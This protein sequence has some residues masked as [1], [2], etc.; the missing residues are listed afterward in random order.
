MC[1]LPPFS[2]SMMFSKNIFLKGWSLSEGLFGRLGLNVSVNEAKIQA[3][4]F[5]ILA[6]TIFHFELFSETGHCPLW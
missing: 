1:L 4:K 2:P 6:V 3:T 5:N